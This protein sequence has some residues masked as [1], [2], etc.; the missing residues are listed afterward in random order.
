MNIIN[1]SIKVN[2]FTEGQEKKNFVGRPYYLSYDTARILIC[3]AWKAQVHGIPSGAFLLAFYMGESGIREAVLLRA[4]K[5]TS[6]PTDN[7]M[8]SSM[9]EYYKDNME[10]SGRAGSGKQSQLDEFT[11][12]EFSF[13]GLECRVLGVFYENNEGIIEFGADL[14][15]FYSANNYNVYKA[16]S[17]VLEYIVNQRDDNS[18]VGKRSEFKIGKVRYSSTQRQQANELKTAVYI[19]SKDLLGKRTA[20]FGMTRTGKSNTVKKIIEATHS[21]SSGAKNI[22]SQSLIGSFDNE[23]YPHKSVGQ[24]IFDIN[25]EYA[26]ANKQDQ[27]TAVFELFSN[28]VVRYSTIEKGDEFRV[29]RVNFFTEIVT[30]FDLIRSYFNNNNIS[31]D[32]LSNFL[33]VE[34]G[35]TDETLNDPYGSAATRLKRNQAAYLC[36]LHRAQ[37]SPHMNFKVT[38]KGHKSINDKALSGIKSGPQGHI[39]VSL[40]EACTWFEWVWNNYNTDEFFTDYK[41]N[42]NKDWADSDLQSL[43]VMLTKNKSPQNRIEVSGWKKLNVKEL[44]DLHTNKTIES[45]EK[46]IPL[47]LSEGKIVIVDLSQGAPI[48]QATFSERICKEVFKVAM[49]NFIHNKLN[50]FIQFYFEEAHNLFPKK[51]DKDLSLIYNRIAKEGA[52]LNLGMIYAT[53]EVSSISSNI[54]KNTQNWFI[55]HLNNSDETKELEKY[56]DFKDFTSSLT[57]FSAGG[58]KGFVR[59]KTY[60]NP[61]VVPVQIDKF[62]ADKAII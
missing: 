45:F 57:R 36:C 42:K 54:L 20:L 62:L 43:L 18:V 56:Y 34:L 27:G 13:S 2:L 15:N 24:I 6:L 25:G 10:I 30:G 61:F 39:T 32:Y 14:E 52:K 51:D 1:S 47:L 12:Y 16:T 8:I 22:D 26:N 9:V 23:G 4:I 28:D 44:R 55:A 31:S 49:N 35:D 33:A 60:T 50:N 7:D 37:F 21:I 29:M 3:D 53:Q 41:K 5:Q 58:D 46:E 48:V 38:F 19:D 40:E 11:R 17:D 59:M